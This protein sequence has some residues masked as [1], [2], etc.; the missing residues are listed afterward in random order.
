MRLEKYESSTNKSKTFFTFVSEGSKGNV[1][2]GV[3]FT[4]IKAK[5]F[6]NLYNEINDQVV[7]DNKDMEKVIATVASTIITF[8]QFRP[9]AEV[10]FQGSNLARTRL[11]QIAINKYFDEI[12]DDFEIYGFFSNKWL[13]FEK[14]INYQAFIINRKILKN[15]K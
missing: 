1:L 13:V 11:Y 6:K 10:F 9:T 14:D 2:K 7:T 3:L 5:G 4:K 8:T 15:E 12:S